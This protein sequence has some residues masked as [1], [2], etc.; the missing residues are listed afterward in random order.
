MKQDC[1][2]ENLVKLDEVP[3]RG[4]RGAWVRER[5]SGFRSF[6]VAVGVGIVVISAWGL[7]GCGGTSDE[8]AGE[9][10]KEAGAGG[11]RAVRR[12]RAHLDDR[13]P[14]AR[15]AAL[16]SLVE[17]RV[18]DAKDLA[19]RGLDDGNATVRATAAAGLGKLDDKDA[20]PALVR[21]A[22]Q[23]ADWQVRLRAVEALGKLGGDA[24]LPAA[25]AALFDPSREVRLEAIDA[26]RRLGP[27]SS[28]EPL[29]V[30]AAEDGSWKN[31]ARAA[32]ALG[33]TGKPEAYAALAVPLKDANE[34]VRS[35]AAGALRMLRER[36]VSEVVVE[37]P[38]PP[39]EPPS[40]TSPTGANVPRPA[41]AGPPKK[42]T[43]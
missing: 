3:S 19:R 25:S 27:G 43:D 13:D 9:I 21:L 20:V 26:L 41:S 38:A 17:A 32:A 15:A 11:P 24:A 8:K 10:L 40:Q 35:A 18:P 22:T 30:I 16:Y 36:G 28:L 1:H 42:Q 5:V 4:E 39:A 29:A 6:G 23:D 34:F 2:A 33:E 31:R 12:I 37:E 7:V 14:A